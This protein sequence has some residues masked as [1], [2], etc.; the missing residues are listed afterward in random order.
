M[1][2]SLIP[3]TAFRV[4]K[5]WIYCS[6]SLIEHFKSTS[7]SAT[8]D[9]CDKLHTHIHIGVRKRL[10]YFG[11]L[12][13]S[14]YAHAQTPQLVM[15]TFTHH[16]FRTTTWPKF[17]CYLQRTDKCSKCFLLSP[18]FLC[19]RRIPRIVFKTIC[20]HELTVI[21]PIH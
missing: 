20:K 4:R 21:L 16:S 7:A 18:S 2:C 6:H 1:F 12:V 19:N 11:A 15:Y 3:N 5:M 17:P 13:I 9:Q 10:A 14:N 8:I